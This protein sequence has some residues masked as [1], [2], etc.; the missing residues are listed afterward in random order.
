MKLALKLLVVSAFSLALPLSAHAQDSDTDV[1][2][3]AG[4]ST[5]QAPSQA[6]SDAAVKPLDDRIKAVQQKKFIK[7]L[8]AE[9]FPWAGVTLNDAF[10]RYY[11][12]GLS[13]TFHIMDSLAVELNAS[14]APIRQVLEPVIFL[15][16]NKSAIPQAARYFGNIGAN[17]QLS[18]IYGKVALFSEWIIH[19]DTFFL[20][21]LGLAAD[22]AGTLIHP[23][24]TMGI[25]QRV[26]L[27][28]WLVLRADV[29]GSLYPQLYLFGVSNLQNQVTALLGV[30]FYI[31]P[32][33]SYSK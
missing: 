9:I 23:Q 7:R 14:V 21:G 32:T 28:D 12:V 20:G 4:A 11:S 27:F 1:S 33:F 16:Q 17:L 5:S 18:P 13:G 25:G 2:K 6:G 19:F 3:E 31:P 26:F 30:G 24:V 22:S 8:R 15:R 10:Y 29:R